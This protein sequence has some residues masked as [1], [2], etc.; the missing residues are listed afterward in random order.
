MPYDP[1][2]YLAELSLPEIAEQVAQRKLPPVE[3]W[4]PRSTGDSFMR[5]A[6]D[7]TWYHKGDPIRRPAMVRAFAG[8]LTRDNEG[9]HLKIL[10]RL[11][12]TKQIKPIETTQLRT[13]FQ[14]A[15][16]PNTGTPGKT[17]SAESGSPEI[18]GNQ[19]RHDALPG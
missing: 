17:N 11:R 4:D 3:Q 18:T 2:P 1:P 9:Q 16:N 19:R 8:L 15:R 5:I 14:V 13:G 7:G 10:N 6:E 12:T